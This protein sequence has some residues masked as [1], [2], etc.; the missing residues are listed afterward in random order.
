M[1][2]DTSPDLQLDFAMV[3]LGFKKSIDVG[4]QR[5]ASTGAKA[6]GNGSQSA[7]DSIIDDGT[8]GVAV[9]PYE[10]KSIPKPLAVS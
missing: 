1:D 7:I 5:T 10:D 8:V 2:D 6:A 3:A 9:S 4:R